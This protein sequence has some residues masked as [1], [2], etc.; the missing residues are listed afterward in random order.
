MFTP[1][2]GYS[3]QIQ[4]YSI[5]HLRTREILFFK[6]KPTLAM[7]IRNSRISRRQY[8]Q[9]SVTKKRNVKKN[10]VLKALRLKM[11]TD[12][13]TTNVE[14]FIHNPDAFYAIQHDF[15]TSLTRATKPV[16]KLDGAYHLYKKLQHLSAP[17][18]IVKKIY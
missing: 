15:F 10:L 9:S 1:T 18:L 14:A 2:S 11:F 8:T 17:Y 4:Y 13:T 16:I 6:S 7:F 5:L 12:R 3:A